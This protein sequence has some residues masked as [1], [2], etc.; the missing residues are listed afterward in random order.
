M[1][2]QHANDLQY[3]GVAEVS[4]RCVGAIRRL[5]QFGNRVVDAK[6]LTCDDR[7]AF[8]LLLDNDE[9]LAVKSGFRSG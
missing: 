9:R 6:L 4:S 8:L 5:L 3:V 1:W 7:H 2:T